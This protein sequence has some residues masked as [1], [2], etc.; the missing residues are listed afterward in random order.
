MSQHRAVSLPRSRHYVLTNARVPLG[1][2]EGVDEGELEACI[3][4]LAMVDIEVRDGKVASI[5]AAGQAPLRS[6]LLGGPRRVDL[7]GK[8]VLPTFADLHTHI[9]EGRAGWQRLFRLE[10]KSCWAREPRSAACTLAAAHSRPARPVT[11]TR[12][13]PPSAAATP[14]AA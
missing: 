12:A 9:G 2:L 8:M 10:Y 13:T 6:A 1:C 14:T 3:D 11:Q 4:R 7:R 5:R